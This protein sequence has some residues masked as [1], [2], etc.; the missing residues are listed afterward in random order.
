MIKTHRK[1]IRNCATKRRRND[2]EKGKHLM[3][4]GKNWGQVAGE[5]GFLGCWR[6]TA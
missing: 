1:S 2:E 5:L 4:Q 3:I 6:E